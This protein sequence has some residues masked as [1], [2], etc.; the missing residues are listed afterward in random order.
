MIEM[1][2]EIQT[3]LEVQE[4]TIKSATK[5]MAATDAIARESRASLNAISSSKRSVCVVMWAAVALLVFAG[6]V[7]ALYYAFFKA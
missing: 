3:Q 5:K 4:H 1:G 7:A 6:V 2:T